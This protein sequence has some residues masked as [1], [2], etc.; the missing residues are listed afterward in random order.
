MGFKKYLKNLPKN[1]GFL[2]WSW[3]QLIWIETWFWG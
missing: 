1:S 2:I 3:I